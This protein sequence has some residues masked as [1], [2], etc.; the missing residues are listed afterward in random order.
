MLRGKRTIAS[1][2]DENGVIHNK[3]T[4]IPQMGPN[5][6]REDSFFV[7]ASDPNL[8]YNVIAVS[9]DGE[10]PIELRNVLKRIG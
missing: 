10:E 6:Y 2:V 5:G 4:G 3:I 9:K 1:W 7:D 8:M